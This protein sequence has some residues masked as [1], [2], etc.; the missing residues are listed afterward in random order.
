MIDR[1]CVR[2]KL[3]KSGILHSWI[4][5]EDLDPTEFILLLDPDEFATADV[6]SITSTLM[7]VLPH[8][9]VWVIARTPE[10]DVDA[11]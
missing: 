2:N 6:T 5:R 8:T 7:S 10:W 3:A 1:D 4:P 11:L 9:K